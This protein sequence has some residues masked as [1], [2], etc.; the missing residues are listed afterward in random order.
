MSTDLDRPLAGLRVVEC[1]T[2]VAGPSGGM[3]LAQL[4][5]DV[6]RVDAIGG[7]P[8]HRRWPL[9]PAGGSLYWNGLNK[10]KRSVTVDLS[11]P[12]GR[13]LVTA[14][15]TAPGPQAGIL[16]ENTGRAWLSYDTLAKRRPDLI[17]LRIQGHADGRPAVDY[18]VNAATGVPDVTGPETTTTPVNH[19][20]PAWDLLTGMTATTGLL[21]ALHRRQRTGRG[22]L[23]ELALADVALASVAN[24]GWLAEAQLSGH[25]RAKQGN[26]LYGAFGVDF[27]TRDGRRVMVVALTASQW[28]ALC[29]ATGTEKVFAA[30]GEALRAD[31]SQD[32]DRYRWRKVIEPI[33]RPW[34][35]D[36]TAEEA[37]RALDAARVLWGP[38]R[39]FTEAAAAGDPLIAQVEQPGTGVVASAGS[40]LRWSGGGSAP[41]AAAPR[42]GAHTHEVLSD[43]LGLTRADL[44][45]LSEAG[46]IGGVSP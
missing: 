18:T 20:L 31:F 11:A 2:F 35:E 44:S 3:A 7:G 6:I 45:R 1:A 46:V 24:L 28:R 37:G 4:G 40:P 30:M 26:H 27:A 8:D 9:A 33:L 42:L 22:G 34:F 10:G 36:R 5:A 43:V 29:R 16:L 32:D 14:L 15:V 38:Y 41:P 23:I 21:A 13:E 19:V 17:H 12:E 39:T 25:D